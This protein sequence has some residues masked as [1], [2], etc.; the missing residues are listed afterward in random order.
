MTDRSWTTPSASKARF[1]FREASTGFQPDQIN[2]QGRTYWVD[3]LLPF[4]GF[5]RV[6][7]ASVVAV[8]FRVTDAP[9][10]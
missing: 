7:W 6:G 1:V 4:N 10:F 8:S 9:Q 5:G 3:K 2:W